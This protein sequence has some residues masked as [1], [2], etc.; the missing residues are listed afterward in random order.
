MSVRI[1]L[2][3]CIASCPSAAVLGNEE[4]TGPPSP[5]GRSDLARRFLEA[6][7]SFAGQWLQCGPLY[8][9]KDPPQLLSRGAVNP[10]VR[11]RAV[12]QFGT[13]AGVPTDI[14]FSPDRSQLVV[15]YSG[16]L[17]IVWDIPQRRVEAVLEDV[18]SDANEF[19]SVVW[20]R[21]GRMLATGHG[22]GETQRGIFRSV[23]LWDAR[24]FD[25]VASL[26]LTLGHANKGT[27]CFSGPGTQ[28]AVG[29][30]IWDVGGL[31]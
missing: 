26:P 7:E 6:G 9:A 15:G 13:D 27:V 18:L 30:S 16:N 28:L 14:A 4:N 21:D 22:M 3:L 17:A 5:G 8:F 11:D 12:R 2:A 23:H 19:V 25:K 31:R 10:R 20:S 1:L 24:S 29:G